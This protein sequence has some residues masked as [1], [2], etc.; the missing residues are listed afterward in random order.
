[1]PIHLCYI[2]F[3]VRWNFKDP[4]VVMLYGF[5]LSPKFTGAQAKVKLKIPQLTLGD[6]AQMDRDWDK[7]LGYIELH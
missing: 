5:Y 7:K 2:P 1:M 4:Y 6:L 3:L